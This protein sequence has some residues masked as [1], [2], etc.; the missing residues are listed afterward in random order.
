MKNTYKIEVWSFST[1]NFDDYGG[2]YTEEDV[3]L[4]TKGYC[5]DKDVTHDEATRYFTRKNGTKMFVVEKE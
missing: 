4:I 2:G 5:L 1:K 3:Q